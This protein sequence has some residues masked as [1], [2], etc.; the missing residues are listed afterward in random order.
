MEV[1]GSE[2]IGTRRR[3]DPLV[4]QLPAA[5]QV[6]VWSKITSA[7]VKYDFVIEYS[8]L[9]P[10]RTGIFNGLKLVI[11]PDVGF[12]MQCF[13]LLHLF[14]HSVQWVAPSLA[15]KLD[16]LQNTGEKEAFLQ[17]LKA[18]ELEAACYGLQL[19]HQTGIHDLDTWYCDFVATDWKYVERFYREDRLP[20][21]DECV[22]Y[23]GPRIVP[24]EIPPLVHRQV[25]VRYAF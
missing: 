13:I 9:E 10:P 3:A 1:S 19:L 24:A 20:P 23:D 21:W 7:I 4:G 11:D 8:D 16:A 5:Q 2:V 12:E 25:Q 14:G 18:Y 15:H 22:V 6:Q 17:V